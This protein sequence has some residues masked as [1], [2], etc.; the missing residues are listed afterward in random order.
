MQIDPS[1][2]RWDDEPQAAP[3]GII[4]GA[5]RQPSP[6]TPAQAQKDSTAV[7]LNELKIEDLR[8]DF[9][10]E[11]RQAAGKVETYQRAG[12]TVLRSTTRALEDLDKMMQGD[13]TVSAFFRSTQAMVPGTDEF[14]FTRQIEDL[15]RNIGLDRLQDMR[16]NS[17]TG[18]ALGQVPVQQQA[19]LEETL[20][21]FDIR[22]PTDVLREN[23]HQLNNIYLDIMFG[24]KAEREQAVSEGKMSSTMSAE[25]DKQYRDTEFN[26]Y[27]RRKPDAPERPRPNFGK[28]DVEP[29]MTPEREALLRKY[30]P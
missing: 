26:I 6:Q 29:R 5:P 14:N 16:D 27:G 3:Q 1:S 15:K 10:K 17:P 30:L 11:Q 9:Q 20:G 13:G 12:Q 25:I 24:S 28:P 21:S 18:G 4:R 7:E 8:R 23:L 19:M 22:Q 2:I